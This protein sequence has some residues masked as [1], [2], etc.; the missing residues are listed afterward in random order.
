MGGRTLETVV[1]E[2][3]LGVQFTTDL[4][5]SR[6]CQLA[7]SKASK[8]LGMIG[9]TVSHKSR[10]VM[11]HLYKSL[12]RPHL[13][14]SIS[15]WSPYYNKDKQ[16]LERLQHRFSRMIPGLKQLPYQERLERL[17]LW[18]LEESRIFLANVQIE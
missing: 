17:G 14:F 13:E 6:Q 15:A 9:R 18:S 7:Y 12:V 8:V 10:D 3:D 11:F 1:E 4:K 16:L 2:K 5:P